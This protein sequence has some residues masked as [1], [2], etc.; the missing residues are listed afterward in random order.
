MTLNKRMTTLK[1]VGPFLRTNLILKNIFLK[2][3][4]SG[5]TIFGI[6]IACS[7]FILILHI[8]EGHRNSWVEV[9]T[10][11][12]IDLFIME[13]GKVDPLTSSL[14]SSITERLIKLKSVRSATG[15]LADI[16]SINDEINILVIGY[17]R[18]SPAYDQLVFSEGRRPRE[19]AETAIGPLIQQTTGLEVGDRIEFEYQNFTITG[20]F[21]ASNLFEAN[22]IIVDIDVLRN[23][24]GVGEVFSSIGVQLQLGI[25][26]KAA[27]DRIKSFLA[28]EYP[29]AK[30]NV[31]ADF[32]SNN[33]MFLSLEQLVSAISLLAFG[34]ITLSCMNTLGTAVFERTG[35]IAMLRTIGWSRLSIALTV[36]S[37]SL[38]LSLFGWAMGI[39]IAFLSTVL[40][41]TQNLFLFMG[42]T[43][44]GGSLILRSALLCILGGIVG[45]LHPTFI[46]L[47]LDPADAF[48]IN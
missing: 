9:F 44:F 29:K 43:S 22:S 34:L 33:R 32:F 1:S 10:S 15:S 23:M 40:M 3:I 6:A 20:V 18:N 42:P 38:L 30:V 31:T 16:L 13:K 24:R 36:L 12:G 39:G 27:I 45:S 4:R 19:K 48:T 25:E 2:P 8:I 28:K 46:A 47:R 41:M 5:L 14:D 26:D 7:V 17:E 21:E 11:R 35:E 37:E